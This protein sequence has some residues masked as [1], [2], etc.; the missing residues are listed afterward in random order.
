LFAAWFV[1]SVPLAVVV[2]RIL[3]RLSAWDH[4]TDSHAQEEAREPRTGEGRTGEGGS[5]A[6]AATG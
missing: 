2:G 4:S 6:G 1:L 3:H 5:S